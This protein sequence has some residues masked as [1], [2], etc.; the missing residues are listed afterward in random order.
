MKRVVGERPPLVTGPWRLEELS[1]GRL[2]YPKNGLKVFSCF[3][4]GGG[5]SM[6]YKLAGFDVIGG[7]E[8]DPEMMKLYHRNVLTGDKHL[9]F[10]MGVQ[11]FVRCEMEHLPPVM[12][13]LDVLDGSPPCSSFSMTGSREKAWGKK[14]FREG[15]AE[16]VLDDLFFDYIKIAKRLQPKVV[17]AENVKGLVIGNAK[18]YVRDIF[19]GY[20]EAG[21]DTQL[22]LLNSSRMG[23]PQSR[24]RIFFVSRRKDLKLPKVEFGFAE[25]PITVRQAWLGVDEMGKKLTPKCTD[26]WCRTLPGQFF[27][28][29][30]NGSW[31]NWI[32]LSMDKPS[33]TLSANCRLTHPEEPRFLGDL[34]AIRLQSFPDDYDFTGVDAR[35]VCGMSVPPIMMQRVATEIAAQLLPP[36]G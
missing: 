5:S 26:I 11:D 13:D 32:R 23:V 17:V 7:V 15:Q 29:A 8:I 12:Y 25:E 2:S 19:R 36:K 18:G 24:E 16:Q 27:S 14:K 20:D 28:K 4:C 3:H 30:N 31:F 21:Y 1:A 10:L 33:S 35:Y 22:F 6:G 34:Q 9:S